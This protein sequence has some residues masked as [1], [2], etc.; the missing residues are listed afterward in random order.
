MSRTEFTGDIPATKK[1]DEL[2]TLI[3][4]IEMAMLTTRGADRCVR[5]GLMQVFVLG[6]PAE[7]LSTGQLG[8]IVLERISCNYLYQVSGIGNIYKSEGLFLAAIDPRRPSR[9]SDRRAACYGD[10]SQHYCIDDSAIHA[11]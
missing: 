7:T 6:L 9:S 10:G 1:L 11:R 3:E 5:E 4:G 8:Q 2:Y